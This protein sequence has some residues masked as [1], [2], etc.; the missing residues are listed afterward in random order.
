M[1]IKYFIGWSLLNKKGKIN[2][3]LIL[4]FSILAGF[5][6]ILV[7][8][9]ISNSVIACAANNNS[10]INFFILPAVLFFARA[11]LTLM[12]SIF[13]AYSLSCINQDLFMRS[14][15]SLLLDMANNEQSKNNSGIHNLTHDIPHFTH[16]YYNSVI[17]LVI[18]FSIFLPLTI[19]FLIISN[20]ALLLMISIIIFQVVTFLLLTKSRLARS[21]QRIQEFSQEF[22]EKIQIAS[23]QAKEYYANSSLDRQSSTFSDSFERYSKDIGYMFAFSVSQKPIVEII[24]IISIVAIFTFQSGVIYTDTESIT[25]LGILM[26]RLVPSIGRISSSFGNIQHSINSVKR[27]L[28]LNAKN[29][30]ANSSLTDKS[31]CKFIC[32]DDFKPQYKTSLDNSHQWTINLYEDHGIIWISGDSGVGKTQFL[33]SFFSIRDHSPLLKNKQNIIGSSKE[34]CYIPQFPENK[35]SYLEYYFQGFGISFERL[36][37]LEYEPSLISRILEKNENLDSHM[38]GGEKYKT[39]VIRML[40]QEFKILLIDEPF[41]SLDDEAARNLMNYLLGISKKHLIFIVSHQQLPDILQN[42]VHILK[43]KK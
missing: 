30:I 9:A 17:A 16:L 31:I 12:L 40:L 38:S 18:E 3:I 42:S 28:N 43:I 39:S 41:A 2:V 33:E 36:K 22:T 10:C 26:Y 15:R 19:Y 1:K 7:S 35:W 11:A 6:D 27:L 32:N 25:A 20:V 5:L 4:T 23:K 29:N 24:L 8:R 34:L 13:S 14:T 37:R 21:A